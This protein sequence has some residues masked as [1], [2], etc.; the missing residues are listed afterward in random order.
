MFMPHHIIWD[1]WSF[2][3]LYVELA[4]L[5]DACRVNRAPKLAALPVSYGDFS[6]WQLGWMK[7]PELKRQVDHWLQRL[8][9]LPP[10]LELPTDRA[11]PPVMSGKGRSC[12]FAL[13]LDVVTPLQNLAS[14]RGTTLYVVLLAAYTMLLHRLNVRLP[15]LKRPL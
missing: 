14:A 4:E 10:A 1:A 5:Y 13:G 6:A 3:L 11:R 2:D 9:P 15:R 8:S 7:G 12:Q